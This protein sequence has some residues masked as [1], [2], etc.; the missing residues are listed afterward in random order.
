MQMSTVDGEESRNAKGWPSEIGGVADEFD[1]ECWRW[2]MHA[3]VG[4]VPVMHIPL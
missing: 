1:V 4:V 3:A 2:L